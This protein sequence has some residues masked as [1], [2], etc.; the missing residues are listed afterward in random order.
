MVTTR[1][2]K[3]NPL[4]RQRPR[5][6]RRTAAQTPTAAPP[7]PPLTASDRA[8]LGKDKRAEVP[9]EAHAAYSADGERPDPISLIEDQ[10][11]RRVPELVPIRYAR[12]MESPFRFYRGA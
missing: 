5:P 1:A 12:M 6:N 3:A 8:A 9:R 10:S 7:A 4:P 11:S 2:T